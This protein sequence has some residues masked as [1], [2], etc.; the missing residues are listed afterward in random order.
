MH[1]TAKDQALGV[2]TYWHLLEFF[3]PFDLDDACSHK[4]STYLHLTPPQL[5]HDKA[6]DMLPWLSTKALVK[7]GGEFG[8]TYHYYLYLLPFDK[9]ALTRLSL[10]H[11]PLAKDSLQQIEFE[12]RLDDEGNTCFAKLSVS[13]EGF[14]DFKSI[15]L[16]TLPWAMGRLANRN[17]QALSAQNY[18]TEQT[19]LQVALSELA[20][21][22]TQEESVIITDKPKAEC[23]S[24][25][26]LVALLSILI[27]WSG[28][29]PEHDFSVIIE[30]KEVKSNK[31]ASGQPALLEKTPDVEIEIALDNALQVTTE[32]EDE[33]EPSEKPDLL[34]ILN[35][36]FIEDLEKS[37][38][39]LMNHEH[40]I[41]NTY[42]AG[43]PKGNRIDLYLAENT[44][45]IFNKLQPQ[46]VNQGRWPD[47]S[48]HKMSMMQQFAINESFYSTDNA[49]IFSVNGPPGTGKTTLLQDIIAENV[50][51]RARALSSFID[52]T[53]TFVGQET[54]TFPGGKTH[55]ISTLSPILTGYEM[56]VASTNNAAVENISKDLPLKRKLGSS[57]QESCRY[58]QPIATKIFSEHKNNKVSTIKEESQPWGLIAVALGNAKNRQQLLD[59]AFWGPESKEKSQDRVKEGLCLTLWE[60]RN[61]YRGPS[62]SQAQKNFKEIDGNLRVQTTQLQRLHELHQELTENRLCQECSVIEQ[63]VDALENTEKHLQQE[64]KNFRSKAKKMAKEKKSLIQDIDQTK[65]MVPGFWQRLFRTGVAKNHAQQLDA[66]RVIWSNLLQEESG[67]RDARLSLDEK[68]VYLKAE[69][70]KAKQEL[71]QKQQQYA[72][73]TQSFEEL[74]ADF[75]G[76][77]FP[78]KDML[79]SDVVQTTAFWV[80]E[81]L[82][83]LRSQLFIAALTLH[84]AWLCEALVKTS[85]RENIFAITQLLGNKRPLNKSHE[86][87]IWQGFF[88]WIPVVSSTFASVARQFKHVGAEALGWLLIDEAGQAIPQAAVGALWR[89]KRVV[90]VGDPRQIEPVFTTPANLIEGLA[91]HGF[92]SADEAY[93]KW[94]P[95]QTSIQHLADEANTFGAQIEIAEQIQWIGSPLRVHRRCLDPMFSIANT[96]AYENKMIQARQSDRRAQRSS[97]LGESCWF[98]VVAEATDKQYVAAQGEQALKLFVKCYVA[99]EALPSL[100][101]ITPFKQVKQNIQRLLKGMETWRHYVPEPFALPSET[102]LNHWCNT[103]IGTVHTFQGKEAAMVIFVLGADCQQLG[104][105]NWAARKPN[106]LNVALTRARDC[107]YI[108]GDFS[109]WS[110]KHFFSEAAQRLPRITVSD[111]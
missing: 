23:L 87:L 52:V 102:Q 37:I 49:A 59:R 105:V 97:P 42:I 95:T 82:N 109:L 100:Y 30:L 91:K 17:L 73:L 20:T 55:T 47:S 106:L 85:F 84:E 13:S 110:S 18:E 101:I 70:Y 72:S 36:F 38:N 79:Q 46:Y 48:Q 64:E 76:V 71:I 63:Q 19:K 58:L 77:T 68:Q 61:N 74:S 33:T 50:V 56:L 57:Y 54:L 86:I 66:L 108:V 111:I 80:N 65:L 40:S 44:H 6:N 94:L 7:A 89:A 45:V 14:P 34:P 15:S 81:T 28:Y 51:R 35:S 43:K 16:S 75:E 22:L 92:S 83:D 11:F 24:A 12:E 10:Q 29:E 98:D 69:I 62:F 96:I 60:W 53:N 8:K 90:V 31:N 9:K 103:H 5:A 27:K 1:S 25:Q 93:E 3:T 41:L 21:H 4:Y 99:N 67:V 2:L 104:S 107:V 26:A 32:G 39:Y 78:P 88:M